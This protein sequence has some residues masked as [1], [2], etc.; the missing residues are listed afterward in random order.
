MYILHISLTEV[1]S[2]PVNIQRIL[3]GSRTANISWQDGV[4]SNP[5]NLPTDSY[6]V[7][8]LND[9]RIVTFNVSTTTIFLDQLLPFTN[10]TI[11]IVARNR[12][13]FSNNSEPFSFV[14]N[15]ECKFNIHYFSL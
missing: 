8:L 15:E 14:T 10:Y 1:P 5:G 9:S 7:L 12:I 3:N 6:Q 11:T 13:G 2:A 4:S